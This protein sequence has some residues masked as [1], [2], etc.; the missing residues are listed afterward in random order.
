MT[1]SPGAQA[2]PSTT[3]RPL[4]SLPGPRGLPLLGNLLQMHLPRLHTLLEDWADRYGSMYIF[5]IARK[6]VVVL[7]DPDLMHEVLRQRPETYRRLSSLAP[8]LEEIGVHGVFAAEGEAWRRQRRIVVQALQVQQLRQFFPT[9]MRLT[10]GLKTRWEQAAATGQAVDVHADLMRYTAEV[11]T[12][13]AF[14]YEMQTLAH[15]GEHL[16]QHLAQLLPAINR[17]VNAPF[18]YWHFIT[19]PADRAFHRAFAAIRTAMQTCIARSRAHLA[20]D[21]GRAAHPRNFLETLLSAR[22]EAGNAFTEAEIMGNVLT[23]LVAGED[24]T[25]HTM[26]WMMHFMTEYPAVQDPMQQVADAVLGRHPVLP[27]FEAHEQ[28]VYIEAVAHETMRLK[29]V[30][31]LL[32]L[33]PRQAVT[34]GGVHLP[35]GTALFLLTRH[36]GLQEHA[37]T[38]AR[39]F[40]PERWLSAPTEPRPGHDPRTFAPFGGG[41]R[42]CPGRNLAFLEIKAVMAMLCR[43]FHLTKA[44]PAPPVHERFAFTMMPTPFTLHLH[45]RHAAPQTRAAD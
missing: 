35:A 44:P 27:H 10:E 26:A 45:T 6:P 16:Q 30:A 43:Q 40:R 37:F 13:L 34:L 21:P 17:R 24:T 19:L 42:F 5:H 22:D 7:A 20:Q 36:G 18:P 29:S 31:P 8:V 12:R 38:E 39:T 23:M 33:E 11:T 15:E 28:L 25:A 1:P 3:G 41:P 14:G 4:A 32:F 2:H 9:L